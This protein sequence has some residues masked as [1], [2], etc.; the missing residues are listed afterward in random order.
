MFRIT[1]PEDGEFV[2]RYISLTR[3]LVGRSRIGIDLILFE[4]SP[5]SSGQAAR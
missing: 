4:E 3:Q 2:I 1:L 5:G